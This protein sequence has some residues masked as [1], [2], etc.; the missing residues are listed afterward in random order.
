MPCR[1]RPWGRV[2][3]LIET[4]S[5]RDPGGWPRSAERSPW[6]R[7]LQVRGHTAAT[8]GMP[9]D[10]PRGWA[11]HGR[12]QNPGQWGVLPGDGADNTL[13]RMEDPLQLD[14]EV[15]FKED[16]LA[17]LEQIGTVIRYPPDS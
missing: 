10:A 1:R 4:A 5:G 16:E 9:V 3:P 7:L 14:L 13:T 12:G 8:S 17:A 15:P 6:W 11:G 2:D